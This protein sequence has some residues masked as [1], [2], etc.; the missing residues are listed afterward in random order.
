MDFQAAVKSM[1]VLQCITLMSAHRI[2]YI[3]ILP[4]SVTCIYVIRYYYLSV[5]NGIHNS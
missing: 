1:L 5:A 3:R 4:I 2:S